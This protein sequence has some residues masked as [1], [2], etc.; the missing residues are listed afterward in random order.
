MQDAAL[1]ER[2]RQKFKSLGPV[3]DERV[4]RQWA[5]AEATAVG[6]GGIAAV[7]AATGMSHNT[8][9]RGVRELRERAKRPRQKA[10]TKRIRRSFGPIRRSW[11]RWNGWWSR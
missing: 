1:I 9:H 2:I 3:M 6:W 4:R 8:I 5:A 7:V 11:K 10:V